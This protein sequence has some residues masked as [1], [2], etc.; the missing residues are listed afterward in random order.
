MLKVI[1]IFA[2]F[3]PIK[4]EA[5]R[6][7]S[8]SDLSILVGQQ[9]KFGQHPLHSLEIQYDNYKSGCLIRNHY[10][11]IGAN[12]N[13]N[14]NHTELGIKLMWNPTYLILAFSRKAKFYPYIFGQGNFNQKKILDPVTK[15]NTLING[16]SL[17]PGLGVTGHYS[18]AGVLSIRTN[19]L[20]GYHL[21]TNN[22]Q[23]LK[24][25]LTIEFKVGIGINSNQLKI[26]KH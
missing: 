26:K 11:G 7:W 12:Y 25:S 14:K 21:P 8:F 18:G 19:L 2:I 10:Y 1:F 20:M 23:N 13:F 17:R 16:Y 4:S 15:D 22:I 9:Y 5:V 24:N 3:F 6:F